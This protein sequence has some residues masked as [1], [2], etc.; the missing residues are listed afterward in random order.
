MDGRG[1]NTGAQPPVEKRT[2][3]SPFEEPEQA[4]ELRNERSEN[5]YTRS[6]P[7]WNSVA[8]TT[9]QSRGEVRDANYWNH[10]DVMDT[11]RLLHVNTDRGLD[12]VR[13][14]LGAG[15]TKRFLAIFAVLV[16]VAFVLYGV[17]FQV[18]TI[19]VV[20]NSRIQKAEIVRLSGLKE[21]QNSLSIDDEAVMRKVESNRYLR[22]TLV[23]VQW[24]SVTIH[25]K[26]R[27]PVAYLNHNGM[28]IQLDNR[29][30]VLE[31]SLTMSAD[32]ESMVKVIGLDVRRCALG[33]TI[34]LNQADQLETYTQVLVELKAMKGLD[35]LRELD[36]SSMESIYLAIADKFYVR[37][38][39]SDNI[40]EK[41]RAFM[42]TREKVIEMG[43]DAGTIDVTN[44]GKPTFAPN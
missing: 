39:S 23:D 12:K 26:E 37:L 31:E 6:E 35:L 21:G 29:G 22:C 11:D 4:P 33:Q 1:W 9:R 24:N 42:I 25:V 8:D 5:L 36:M 14:F 16:V 3:E 40:H 43:Y 27:E 38:G 17:V 13:K 44:P 18:R 30:F 41:L 2:T 10:P 28:V 7:F 34:T 15:A 19:N 20:G 32:V